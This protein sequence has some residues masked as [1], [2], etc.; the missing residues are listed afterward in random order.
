LPPGSG[1][2]PGDAD[3]WTVICATTLVTEIV[4]VSDAVTDVP[5]LSCAVTVTVSVKVSPAVPVKE[6]VNVQ[7][8]VWLGC[9]T[10][11]MREPQ[12]EPGRVARSP[13]TSSVTPVIVTG[14]GPVFVT[15]TV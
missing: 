2:F 14:A 1:T 7:L 15:A 12:V 10:C 13:Y 9:T 6:A 5:P 8:T 4:A 3:F 11:E